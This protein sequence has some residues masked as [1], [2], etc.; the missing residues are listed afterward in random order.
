MGRTLPSKRI[1]AFLVLRA[2]IDPMRFIVAFIQEGVL[3]CSLIIRPSNPI[4]SQYWYR[5][6]SDGTSRGPY[7]GQNR[8]WER[9]G[10]V[11]IFFA[12]FIRYSW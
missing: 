12:F 3:W 4:S 5:P 11:R 6:D 1:L 8:Y 7:A 10:A 2:K 9:S